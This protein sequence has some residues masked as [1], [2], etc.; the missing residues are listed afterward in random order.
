[1][2]ELHYVITLCMVC[3]FGI[4]LYVH[5]SLICLRSDVKELNKQVL[6]LQKQVVIEQQKCNRIIE[7]NIILMEAEYEK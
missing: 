7:Q 2:K 4:A 1:M 6:E 3:L 5:D